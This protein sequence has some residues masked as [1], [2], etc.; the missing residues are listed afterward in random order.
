MASDV[1]PTE[2]TVPQ[3][4]GIEIAT[5][6]PPHADGTPAI[7][8]AGQKLSRKERRIAFW[9]PV[10]EKIRD[11][12]QKRQ[13][14]P[15]ATATQGMNGAPSI[16]PRGNAA[17]SGSCQRLNSPNNGRR[18]LSDGRT[19][20]RVNG[21]HVPVSNTHAACP[22]QYGPYARSPP[23]AHLFAPEAAHQY[24]SVP[25]HATTYA[26]LY[27]LHSRASLQ[28]G[29]VYAQNRGHLTP[30]RAESQSSATQLGDETRSPTMAQSSTHIPECA[31]LDTTKQG[32]VPED[33]DH[34]VRGI[35]PDTPSQP[36]VTESQLDQD[37]GLS[38]DL[39]HEA[40]AMPD[41]TSSGSVP[42]FHFYDWDAKTAVPE[43]K[44]SFDPIMS[45]K[46]LIE[47]QC[48]DKKIAMGTERSWTWPGREV[49][50][51]MHC[52]SPVSLSVV[53][54]SRMATDHPQSLF[55]TG[56]SSD[57][58]VDEPEEDL[59][60]TPIVEEVFESKSNSIEKFLSDRPG[61][62]W[63]ENM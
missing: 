42:K 47:A 53:A 51:P 52:Y 30:P 6:H 17:I 59:P 62:A 36:G 48:I 8:G 45:S 26:P 1:P 24:L 29:F 4:D 25:M 18:R 56:S 3:Q 38:A 55:G 60:K 35:A 28:P 14:H 50:V 34:N 12:K 39:L 63:E 7:G 31:R 44:D 41:C 40:A 19:R 49:D 10:Q 13:E 27:S 11:K 21:Q 37:L 20:Q 32:Y 46:A 61:F 15:A 54:D 9:Q 22:V 2:D 57:T 16:G 58:L 33:L 43:A 5:P 23:G